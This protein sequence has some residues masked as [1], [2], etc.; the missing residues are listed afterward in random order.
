VTSWNPA[1]AR[2]FGYTKVAMIGKPISTIS[3]P[4]RDDEGIRILE[5]LAPGR[6]HQSI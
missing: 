1:A 2:I 3:S 6:A 4:G 5:R